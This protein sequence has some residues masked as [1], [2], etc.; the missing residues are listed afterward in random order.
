MAK[1]TREQP[2]RPG[3]KPALNELHVAV[4]RAITREQP[5]SSLDEVTRELFRRSGIKVSTVTVRKRCAKPALNGSSHNVARP[6][7]RRF[8]ARRPNATATRMRIGATMAP[9]A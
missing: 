8:R 4:L 2:G 6:S 7:V 5:R 9:A 1:R 3:R